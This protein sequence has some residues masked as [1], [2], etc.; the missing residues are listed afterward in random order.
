MKR[1]GALSRFERGNRAFVYMGFLVFVSPALGTDISWT[2]TTDGNWSVAANWSPNSV[3]GSGDNAFITNSG[4]YTVTLDVIDTVSNLVLGGASGTNALSINANYLIV[5]S[6]GSIN[7]NGLLS[8]GGGGFYGTNIIGGVM[9][10]TGGYFNGVLTVASN[11]TLNISGP[12]TKY[13][14]QGTV[15][16][17]YGTNNWTGGTISTLGAT[18]FYNQPGAL[19]DVQC[20]QFIGPG[21]EFYNAGIFQKSAGAGICTNYTYFVN[22]GVVTNSSGTLLFENGGSMNGTIGVGTNANITFTSGISGDS[23]TV[24]GAFYATAGG[25]IDFLGGPPFY[26]DIGSPNFGGAGIIDLASPVIFTVPI[27]NLTL[28]DG[29]LWETNTV[30]GTLNLVANGGVQGY[31]TIASN[32]V[33]NVNSTRIAQFGYGTILTNYGTINWISNQFSIYTAPGE[34]S[35]IYNEPGALFDVQCDGFVGSCEFDNL[36]TFRKS[37]GTGICTNYMYFINT[38]TVTNM[39]GTLLFENGGTMDGTTGVGPGANITFITSFSGDSMTMDGAFYAAAGGEIDFYGGPVF[40]FDVGSFN[41]NGPGIIDM[42]APATF[43]VPITNLTLSDGFLEGTNVVVGTLNLVANSGVQGYLTIASNAVMN[44]NST[45]GVIFGYGTILTN[46]GRINWLGNDYNINTAPGPGN[47]SVIYNEPGAIFDIQC[48]QLMGRAE[49]DNA[50][51]F[52][53]SAGTGVSDIEMY[54]VNSGTIEPLS[55]TILFNRN[56]YNSPFILLPTSVLYFPIGG[57]TNGTQYGSIDIAPINYIQLGGTL[58]MDLTNGFVP[59][60]GDTFPIIAW[61]SKQDG[62]DAAVGR[63]LSSVSNGLYFQPQ[64][65]SDRSGLILAT[66]TTNA[67]PAPAETNLADLVVAVGDTAYFTPPPQIGVVLSYQWQFDETDLPSQTNA[68]LI[69]S[70][71][72][73]NNA[74]DYCE[75][76]AVAVAD[77]SVQTNIYCASLSVLNQQDLTMQPVS[78]TVTNG[79]TIVLSVAAT[80]QSPLSYQWRLNG[81]NIPRANGDSYAVTTDAQPSDGGVYDVLVSSAVRTVVSTG[82]LVIV[83]SPPLPFTDDFRGG[84]TNGLNFVGSGDNTNATSQT[85]EPSIVGNPPGHS[86]WLQWTAPANG[87]MALSTRG[88]TFDTVLAVYTGTGLTNLTLVNSDD[89]SGG[90]FTSMVLFNA[91]AGS[92]YLITVDGSAGST[93]HM[94]L[95]GVFNTNIALIPQILQQ[96]VDVTT[97]AGGTAMFTVFA[98]STTNLTYQW[99]E[100]DWLAI[101]GATNATL[102]LTNVD[103]L[104]VDS[105]SVTVTAGTNLQSVDSLRA[106]LEIGPALSFDKLGVLLRPFSQAGGNLFHLIRFN[107]SGVSFPSVSAGGIGS[108][109]INNFNSTT[110]SGEPIQT[111]TAGGSSRWY[112]LAAATNATLEIDTMGS[113]IATLLS[114]YIGADILSLKLVAS[115]KN[116]AP[117]GIHSLVRFPTMNG[118]NYLVQVDGV[119][120]AQ[121]N[122]YLNWHMGILPN[123]VTNTQSAV[124]VQGASLLLKAGESNDVTAPA[125]QWKLNGATI[126]GATNA[127]LLLT[128]VLF[129]QCGSYSVVISNL[130][131]AATNTIALISVNAPLNLALDNAVVPPNFRISG[132]TTQ[133]VMLQLSTNLTSWVP[134]YTNPT[135]LL[136]VNYLDTNSVKRAEGFYRLKSWP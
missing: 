71:A 86:L 78:Q 72:Q 34:Q 48:D 108:Q 53:K 93:G 77:A 80:S 11:A 90:Y 2:N 44:V 35:V 128:N 4:T 111:N 36:G 38:G 25:E 22:S 126:A 122:I 7:T 87:V 65:L 82:A 73:T 47:Y 24:D 62:F 85:G 101:P 66:K 131:G 45:R 136:P 28:S 94:V 9:N 75:R 109:L 134:V 49:F 106:T 132:S 8:L 33:M 15:V 40:Y 5:S 30:V 92:N 76:V 84:S 105:Y 117:D 61:G 26:F 57:E 19:F 21:M 102:I 51:T 125:Y 114:V 39:S 123:V 67:P 12:A 14:L 104:D 29:F 103:Y 59:N 23:F 13:T 99:Y 41:F 56:N 43:T 55:G 107:A 17:N 46:Y 79:S 60:V 42:A 110:E 129:N 3:P 52:R 88:S 31:L 98:A 69:L 68:S 135:P 32:A 1:S 20:D 74:G 91:A 89:D 121:G 120:G 81:A 116:D 37:A 118:T 127:T 54:F 70:G 83:T 124:L 100:G 112:L 95:S 115:D 50:G 18:T 10:W 63:D 113:D 119:N 64:V 27:T 133:A 58:A 96:P 6:I 130:V 16:I 97:V